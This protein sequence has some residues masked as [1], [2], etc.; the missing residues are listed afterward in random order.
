MNADQPAHKGRS[1]W[2]LAAS[3]LGELLSL[4]RTIVDQLRDLAVRQREI[5]QA[6]AELRRQHHEHHER[7]EP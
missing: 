4:A 1:G 6:I 2:T 7:N 3:M 5:E